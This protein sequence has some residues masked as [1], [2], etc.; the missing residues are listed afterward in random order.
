MVLWLRICLCRECIR[1]MLSCKGHQNQTPPQVKTHC[2]M[3]FDMFRILGH[4][5]PGFLVSF[6]AQHEPEAYSAQANPEPPTAHI[7]GLH[8]SGSPRHTEP[9]QQP[10][11]PDAASAEPLIGGIPSLG[12]GLA[13]IQALGLF[14]MGQLWQHGTFSELAQKLLR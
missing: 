5:L 12:R 14:V 13:V 7:H 6:A 4:S 11:R 10:V 9:H 3:L 8:R 1:L 2:N